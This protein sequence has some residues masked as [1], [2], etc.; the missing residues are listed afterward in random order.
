[1]VA[2]IGNNTPQTER[3][4][5]SCL[6]QSASANRNWC[7]DRC[8]S[9]VAIMLDDDIS[10]FYPGWHEDLTRPFT[11]PLVCIVS[12][13]LMTPD[14]LLALTCSEIYDLKPETIEV[15]PSDHCAVPTAAIAFRNV[16]VRFDEAFRGSGWEDN[17]FCFQFRA[18]NPDFKIIQSNECRLIHANEQ[19]NQSEHWKHNRFYFYSK[20]HGGLRTCGSS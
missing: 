9:D 12:A 13:R 16:G 10:G 18:R 2:E 3:V 20:W 17:D 8:E 19:K 5:A 1:M 7:L 6:D 14:G 11:D 15:V 4:L